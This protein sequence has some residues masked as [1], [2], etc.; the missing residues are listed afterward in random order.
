LQV[1]NRLGFSIAILH[2]SPNLFYVSLGVE[3]ADVVLLIGTNPRFEAPL[4]N[5]RLR[6]AWI[7]NDL[8]VATVGPKIDLTYDSEVNVIQLYDIHIAIVNYYEF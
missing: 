6:K 5:A 2:H 1:E 8:R 3:E 7:N 4:F